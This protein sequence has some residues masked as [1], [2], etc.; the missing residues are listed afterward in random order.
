MNTEKLDRVLGQATDNGDV[1]GVVAMAADRNGLIYSGAFGER[2]LGSGTPMSE[3]TVM[4]FASMTK[5]VTGAAAMQLVEQGKLDL[6]APA[7]E[8]LPE[9]AEVQV[10]AGFEAE[11]PVLRPP[12][13]PV[14]LRKLL[15]HT[16]GFVYS[17]WNPEL[18]RY[19]Q[20]TG[21][22]GIFSAQQAALDVPLATDPGTR[23]EYGI[24]ID[25]AGRMVEAAS[26]QRLGD[27]FRE[28][29]FA[30]LG[31]TDTAFSM[32]EDAQA[33]LA[34]MH[35][36]SPEGQLAPFPLVLEQNPEVHMG[37]HGLYGPA[38]DYL[39]FTRA[40]LGGGTLDG[41]RILEAE[42]V[43]LMAQNSMGDL[44][45]PAIKSIAPQYSNDV[46]FW[47]DMSKKWGLSFLINSEETPEGRSAGSLAWAG[48]ANSYYWIDRD[49]GV[50][51]VLFTQILPFW[52]PKV[53]PLFQRFEEAV[54]EAL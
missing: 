47:P 15:T 19:E 4:L 8:V 12:K 22:P 33:R 25:W 29:I 49:K 2:E 3:D 17:I 26:G 48:I 45:V 6:D 14:T 23:W 5:A 54:Y 39:R 18:A 20:A 40:I 50:T 31:M 46:E 7:G 52:D 36:R 32:S 51:G 10:L 11:A 27:Y 41:E 16:S 38:G 21:N 1:P 13:S 44:E 35:A 53:V 34:T 24:G 9:L 37:G 30:P 42:T 28:H 43:E